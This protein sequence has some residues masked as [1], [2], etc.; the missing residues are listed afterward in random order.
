[1][2][3][4]TWE[5]DM[6]EQM[7]Y[8]YSCE[9]SDK[10]GEDKSC[11]DNWKQSFYNT[12]PLDLF[13]MG[14]FSIEDIDRLIYAIHNGGVK[15]AVIP[16]IP[17]IRRLML[18][19]ELIA[20]K[21][22]DPEIIE[23]IQDP[24][25]YM[26]RSTVINY[27]FVYG[28]GEDIKRLDEYMYPGHYFERQSQK[29]LDMIAQM[30]GR[31]IPVVKA[32]YIVQNR[33]LFYLGCYGADL[34]Q[35]MSFIRNYGDADVGRH[36]HKIVDAY[37]EEFGSTAAETITMFC[38]PMQIMPSDTDCVLNAIVIDTDDMC[39]ADIQGDEGRC[40][41]KCMLYKD[42]DTCKYHRNPNS[43]VLRLGVLFL[44][45]IRLNDYISLISQRYSIVNEQ[46]RAFTLP[47]AGN[48][49][50]WSSELV[51]RCDKKNVLFWICPFQQSSEHVMWEIKMGNARNRLI[52]LSDK[53]GCCLNGYLGEK[54]E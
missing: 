49:N 51:Q 8:V 26:Y 5:K 52:T 42:Y 45:N 25:Q 18:K 24:Y 28:N 41:M 48:I 35:V 15:T 14:F 32:G 22:V 1:M 50:N 12:K 33:T 20:N 29:V 40:S 47:N 3:G 30:E 34:Q 46:I 44:G 21:E 7:R 16:Y 19:Q 54:R 4:C 11:E 38:S 37:R 23:F 10:T 6:Q 2:T 27:Y 17:P 39:H 13:V 43:M 36:M 31:M 9:I 53:F